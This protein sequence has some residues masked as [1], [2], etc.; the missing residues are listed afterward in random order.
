MMTKQCPHCLSSMFEP[1][2]GGRRCAY[3]EFMQTSTRYFQ[4]AGKQPGTM[5]SI[6][7]QVEA[8]PEE[9]SADGGIL[10]GWNRDTSGAIG[11][12]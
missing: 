8:K 12:P 3:C 4:K 11:Q 1:R 10:E 9:H 6:M 7:G 2:D 5:T